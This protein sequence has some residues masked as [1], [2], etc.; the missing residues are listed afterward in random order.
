MTE[1]FRMLYKPCKF[2]TINS[3]YKMNLKLIILSI[4][5]AVVKTAPEEVVNNTT[6][7]VDG[8][9]KIVGGQ[10]MDVS[11]I[12]YIVSIQYKRNH[13]CGGSII[14]EY[15]ILSAAHCSQK[16]DPENFAI[17]S[18]SS[19]RSRG[20]KIHKV[21]QII[22]HPNYNANTLDNDFMLMKLYHPLKFDQRHQRIELAEPHMYYEGAQVVVSGYGVTQDP[23]Q[24]TEFLRGVVV[25]ISSENSCKNAYKN[26]ITPNMFCAASHKKDS[27]QGD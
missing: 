3:N 4:F 1:L 7:P 15:W 24:D 18:G 20:G 25:E 26:M 12:P 13:I 8:D 27:C 17:R 23:E 10:I 5:V 9:G 6:T 16:K 11:S 14:S 22:N 19:R 2:N 21:E